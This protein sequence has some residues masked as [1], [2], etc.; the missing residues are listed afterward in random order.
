MSAA[1]TAAAVYCLWWWWRRNCFSPSPPSSSSQA[2]LRKLFLTFF[3]FYFVS[4]LGKW[5]RAEQW[6]T[7][8][9]KHSAHTPNAKD[10]SQ[11]IRVRER[12][13][14]RERERERERSWRGKERKR[15]AWMLNKIELY[16]WSNTTRFGE[17]PPL[18]QNF[19]ASEGL[20]YLL[21]VKALNPKMAKTA[22]AKFFLL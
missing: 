11:R 2:W 22:I 7:S 9:A 20:M 3:C 12:E 15:H 17:I 1:S 21:Y 16:L 18:W 10:I 13:C 19:K 6:L 14:E 5:I 4:F 8:L